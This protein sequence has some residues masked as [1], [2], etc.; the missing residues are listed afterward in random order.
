MENNYLNNT[1]KINNGS[2]CIIHPSGSEYTYILTAKHVLKNI[3]KNK[4]LKIIKYYYNEKG[5]IQNEIINSEIITFHKHINSK[6]DAALIVLKRINSTNN[7]VF[8]NIEKD[9]QYLICGFPTI[10]ND[11]YDEISSKSKFDKNEYWEFLTTEPTTYNQKELEGIS[12]G[13]VFETQMIANPIL[14]GIE[15][16]MTDKDNDYHGRIDIMPLSFFNSKR[17]ITTIT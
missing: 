3:S 11:K 17:K 6:K 12:G 8:S 16:Q 13:G 15:S 1:V 4:D 2:G 7:P 14:V 9:K 10:S 5:N